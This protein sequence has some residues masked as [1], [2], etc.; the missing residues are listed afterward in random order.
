VDKARSR[1]SGGT[2]LGLAIARHMVE[3]QGG[4]I[5]A[6]SELNAGSNFLVTLPKAHVTP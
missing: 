6:E 4:T 2:G 3:S 5:R 1:E